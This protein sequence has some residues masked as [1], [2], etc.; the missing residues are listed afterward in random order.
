MIAVQIFFFL[1][2]VSFFIICPVWFLR[3]S[4]KAVETPLWAKILVWTGY[5]LLCFIIPNLWYNDIITMTVLGIYYLA[6][7]W[8][9]YHRSRT[10]LLYQ[11]IFSAATWAAQ[12]IA[13]FFTVGVN[14]RFTIDIQVAAYMIGLLKGLLML[15]V[16]FILRIIIQ[17]RLV[18]DQNNLHIRG[19][20]IVP[21]FSLILIYLYLGAGEAFFIDYGY[22]WI[23]FF[24]LLLVAINAY[25]L[26]VWYDIS[27]NRE[28]KHKLEL[29]QQQN[30]LTHQY[31]DDM[32]Q[33][34][35]NS[36]KII[37]DIRNHLL[38]L[39][40]SAKIEDNKYFEDVH[41]MLNSLG[42]KF[43]SENKMLNIVLNDKLKRLPSEA[44]ECNMGGVTLDFISDMD[45]TTI[46]ANLLDNAVESRNT[47]HEFWLKIRGEQ[48]QDFTVVK[49]WNHFTGKYN[50][51]ASEKAGHE[52]LGLQ[53]VRHAVE[54][55]N[56]E[57]KIDYGNDIFSVT[58]VFPGR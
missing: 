55:Y 54:K 4:P 50:P 9:L 24:C 43:Y 18:S 17:N 33:N 19:M 29:M 5:G 47:Q 16:T 13:I 31:Y 10:W 49:I 26:H 57:L 51:G 32:E 34:Y 20:V 8:F 12:V 25:C 27:K 30:E 40:Q 46:F 7:G 36:R 15:L 23:I 58:L 6:A 44:V 38:M 14:T 45:I 1:L 37:H 39:E 28:L 42:L 53:N 52:G 11:L 2:N 21:V 41:G 35:N 48:I 56:G 3:G 22:K